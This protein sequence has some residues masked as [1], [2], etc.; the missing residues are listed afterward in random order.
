MHQVEIKVRFRAGHRL[1]E[2][3]KG[4]CN[5]PHGEGYTAILIFESDKLD[6]NGMVIDFGKVKKNVQEVVNHFYDHAFFF[7][8]K[9]LKGN[10]ANI[11]YEQGFR[12]YLFDENPT[13]E[14]IAKDLFEKIKGLYLELK[15]VGIIESFDDSIAWYEE[16]LHFKEENF[17]WSKKKCFKC[18]KDIPNFSEW[19]LF[20]FKKRRDLC[21]QKC[22]LDFIKYYQAEKEVEKLKKFEVKKRGEE[23]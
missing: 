20:H 11:F 6:E 5:N 4:K 2:P 17:D 16:S 1:M 8:K 13:A 18:G 14:V 21:S 12:V 23:K 9:D 15:K 22:F 19:C 7:N 10:L 3:Y